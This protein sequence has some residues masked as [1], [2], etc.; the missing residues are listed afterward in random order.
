MRRD[1]DKRRLEY[2][3]RWTGVAA[4]LLGSG[5]RVVEEGLPG[6]TTVH[7]DPIEGRHKNGLSALPM[8]L[9][10]H[11]PIDMLVIMLGT[12]DLKTRFSLTAG[13]IACSEGK[14]VEAA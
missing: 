9:E 5:W 2:E 6:R 10:S 11:R 13:D 14:L 8:V 1:D 4:N 12:N 7:D 3:R